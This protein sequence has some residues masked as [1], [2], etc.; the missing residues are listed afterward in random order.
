MY[1]AK[2]TR[3][4]RMKYR[5]A[6]RSGLLMPELSLGIWHNWGLYSD[7]DVMKDMIFTAFDNGITHI[8]AAN[9]Y[10]PP[11]G[12][13]EENLGKILSCE[14]AGYRDELL[15]S[16]KAGYE[17]WPGPYG[18][19]GGRKYL[20]ASLD[21]SLERLH[22]D[23]VD[24]FYHHR[25][26]PDTPLEETVGALADMVRSGKTIYVG[27]S[28][29]PAELLWKATAMME[30][31]YSIHPVL[32]QVRYSIVDRH[33]E[34]DGL[35]QTVAD[36]GMSVSVFSP[37]AQGLLTDKY[38]KGDIPENSRAKENRF[39]KEETITSQL[40]ARLNVLNEIAETRGETL[41]EMAISFILRRPEVATVIIGA[42]NSEQ[43][44]ANLNALGKSREFSDEE[45]GEI[46]GLF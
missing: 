30:E 22:L 40:V 13:A 25:P 38:L 21:R 36:L 11:P 41:S 27:F 39:L 8:D 17:M 6:G 29:Y 3:Y 16:T 7:Y 45:I 44:R 2:T 14:L 32:D 42:R 33:I 37:L 24:I 20:M 1:R 43:I 12:S 35:L 31:T 15:I 19:W 5:R 4:S 28:N 26:D 9:N 34:E 10:G 46:T 18:N 23:Y